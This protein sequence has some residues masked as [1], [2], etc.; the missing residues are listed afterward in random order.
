VLIGPGSQAE[1]AANIAAFDAQLPEELWS[2]MEREGLI[3]PIA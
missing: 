3:R 1:L 2:E